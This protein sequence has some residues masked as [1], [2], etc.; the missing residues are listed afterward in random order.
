MIAHPGIRSQLVVFKDII[1]SRSGKLSVFAFVFCI[2]GYFITRTILENTIRNKEID[3]SSA[4]A[5]EVY[6]VWG[7]EHK[8]LPDKKLWPP[9]SYLKKDLVWSKMSVKGRRFIADLKLSPGTRYYCW[10][11]QTKDKN[12][13]VAEIWNSGAEGKEYYTAGMPY[14]LLRP[15]YFVFLAGVLPLIIAYKR[16]RDTSSVFKSAVPAT[17]VP[18]YIPQLDALRALAVMLVIIHHWIPKDS[19]VHAVPNGSL[20]VNTFFVLS[21]F[22]ITTIL[23][24]AKIDLDQNGR[25]FTGTAFKNF[26]IRR[27]L[28][29]FPIYYLLLIAFWVVQSPELVKNPAPYFTYT[30]NILFFF[31]EAFP[32]RLAHLWSLAVE[33]QFYLLWPWLVLLLNKRLLRYVILLF[34]VVGV[35]T[36]YLLPEQG[37]WVEIMTPAC[38]DAFAIGAL[39]AYMTVYRRDI[40]EL[41]KPLFNMALLLGLTLFTFELLDYSLLPRRTVHSLLAGL[42]IYYCL[43]KNNNLIANK[44]LNNKWLIEIGKISYGIYLYHLFIPELWEHMIRR[45]TTNHIDVFF[46]TRVPATL[47][48]AYLLVQELVL[49]LFLSRM[50]W[51]IV[52]RPF[53]SLKRYFAYSSPTSSVLTVQATEYDKEHDRS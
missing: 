32:S 50:S 23:L 9:N 52:E 31:R 20:G 46:N 29:I 30:S 37:W 19:W 15:G 26:Y 8:V 45:L 35:S 51:I 6:L 16:K 3:Y 49:L 18:G 21:G 42:V 43:Y 22:L 34:I 12:G 4:N 41:A 48:P 36:N 2:C 53:N 10:F 39:L 44:V 7:L 14:G 17:P 13:N 38:F 24:K 33:E 11:V 25:Q 5:K 1:G 40:A 27:T 47:T 28:R